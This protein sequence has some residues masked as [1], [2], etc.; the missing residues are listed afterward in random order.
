MTDTRNNRYVVVSIINEKRRE[1]LFKYFDDP[2]NRADVIE[3]TATKRVLSVGLFDRLQAKIDAYPHARVSLV[4]D[5]GN[6][7]YEVIV[8]D[9]KPMSDP[10]NEILRRL[11]F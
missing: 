10:Y 8:P 6:G 9:T 3:R 7:E 11:R 2:K 1:G 5:A 4:E